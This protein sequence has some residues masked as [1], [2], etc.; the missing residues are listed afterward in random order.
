MC[1][2]VVCVVY[3][4]RS[5]GYRM[6]YIHNIGENGEH[7]LDSL[8]KT[9]NAICRTICECVA[10]FVCLCGTPDAADWPM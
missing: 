8:M 9:T 10:I 7:R 3:F 2:F 1:A 5:N 6:E 4:I